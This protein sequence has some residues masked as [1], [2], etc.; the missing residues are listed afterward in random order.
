MIL[1]DQI[2]SSYLQQIMTMIPTHILRTSLIVNL[3]LNTI[4]SQESVKGIAILAHIL[5]QKHKQKV[6]THSKIL[7]TMMRSLI[8]GS[9]GGKLHDNWYFLFPFF[10][11]N[12]LKGKS[13]RNLFISKISILKLETR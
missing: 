6:H 5:M 1:R 4:S 3:V 11:C 2:D 12:R 10:F 8:L 13:N 7:C 9:N